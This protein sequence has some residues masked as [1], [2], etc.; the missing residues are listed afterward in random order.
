MTAKG[1]GGRSP[2]PLFFD[3]CQKGKVGGEADFYDTL[4]S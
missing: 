2:Q 4:L 1:K 3:S